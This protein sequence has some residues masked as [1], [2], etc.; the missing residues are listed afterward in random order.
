MKPE[1]I[2]QR[3]EAMFAQRKDIDHLCYEL[4]V[5]ARHNQLIGQRTY[6]ENVRW[7]KRLL[8]QLE[9]ADLIQLLD[10]RLEPGAYPDDEPEEW[11]TVKVKGFQPHTPQLGDLIAPQRDE[12]VAR[13]REGLQQ[14]DK[15]LLKNSCS[16]RFIG[17]L[18]AMESSQRQCPGCPYC[19]AQQRPPAV[20]K[21][22]SFSVP[23]SPVPSPQSVWVEGVPDYSTPHSRV[24]FV[25]AISK[26]VLY[27]ELRSFW[28]AA[29]QYEEVLNCF[30]EAFPSN[31]MNLHRLDPLRD[32][33]HLGSATCWPVVFLHFGS[34]NGHALEMGRPFPCVHLFSGHHP[35]G[36]GRDV[37][38]S[39]GFRRWISFDAWLSESLQSSL[40]C[41]P[42]PP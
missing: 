13:F 26:C 31:T 9:R 16:G 14:L 29:E 39:E 3:W 35:T 36:D 37:V 41:L 23:A 40:P 8:L 30:A 33:S 19:R 27:K 1:M 22:L 42:T 34:V 7:N 12:E 21:P 5:A 2:Q 11:V 4:P 28:C 25:D 17:K 20:C 38:V 15:F 18:Y 10:L 24:H 32:S 6:G